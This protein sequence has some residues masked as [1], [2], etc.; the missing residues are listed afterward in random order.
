[1]YIT[2]WPIA[3]YIHMKNNTNFLRFINN[4]EA[5]TDEARGG[6]TFEAG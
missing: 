1:M 5:V 3:G 2:H 4:W 6:G